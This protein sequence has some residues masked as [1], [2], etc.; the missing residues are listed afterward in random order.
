M[1]IASMVNK[2]VYPSACIVDNLF[3]YIIGGLGSNDKYLKEIEKY[4][5]VV[6]SMET[7]RIVSKLQLAPRVQA[8]SFCVNKSYI[9]IAGGNCNRIFKDSYVLDTTHNTL[10]RTSDLPDK[11]EFTNPSTLM[12]GNNLFALC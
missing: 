7:I 4:S 8:L 12:I 1:E 2:K 6:N 5:I 3:I 10:R 11:D 9:L